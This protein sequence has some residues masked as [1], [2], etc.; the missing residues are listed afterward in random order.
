[1]DTKLF[2]AT[3]AF[4]ERD[5][6]VL[7]VREA[8]QYQDGTNIGRY[9]VPG[10]R[11]TPGEQW[12]DALTREVKEETGLDITVGTPFYVGEWRPTPRGEQWQIIGIFFGCQ[13]SGEVTLGPDH[14]AFEWIDPA[15]H[16]SYNIIPNLALAFAEYGRK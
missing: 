4:I 10:G 14:D 9:D 16:A 1:M 5:G 3:K 12:Q 11:L 6:K 8:G 7:V 13:A 2:I 15:N